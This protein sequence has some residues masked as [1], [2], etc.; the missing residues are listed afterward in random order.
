MIIERTALTETLRLRLEIIADEIL[1][2]DQPS[3]HKLRK[4]LNSPNGVQQL[5]W[6][7]VGKFG[8]PL[9]FAC[10]RTQISDNR[11][12]IIRSGLDLALSAGS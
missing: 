3:Y 1:E 6:I 12:F 5:T 2:S 11:D 4:L 10:W 9:S 8:R 7:L